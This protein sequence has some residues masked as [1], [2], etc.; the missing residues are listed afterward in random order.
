MV[1]LWINIL[2]NYI[3]QIPWLLIAYLSRNLLPFKNRGFL[4]DS[5]HFLNFEQIPPMIMIWVHL[6]DYN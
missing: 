2:D 5:I 1:D 6:G 3:T 4:W